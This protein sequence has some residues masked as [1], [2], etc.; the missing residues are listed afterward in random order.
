MNITKKK[1]KKIEF[2]SARLATR[3]KLASRGIKDRSAGYR[4]DGQKGPHAGISF[5]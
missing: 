2:L 5:R 3:L 1:Q 4:S